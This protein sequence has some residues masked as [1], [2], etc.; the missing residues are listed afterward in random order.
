M[1]ATPQKIYTVS[2]LNRAAGQ[3]LEHHFST[4]TVEGEIGRFTAASSGHWY[5]S[6][7]DQA[8]QLDCAMFRSQN[9]RV[10]PLPGV[11]DRVRVQG[12]IGIYETRG[13]FQLVVETLEQSG[14]GALAQ[15][16]ERL[17]KRLE[18]EGLFARE[19]KQALPELPEHL[20]VITSATGAALQDVLKVLRRRY[21]ILP[22]T[23][24]PVVVQGDEAVPQ[25]VAALQTVQ[26]I[27]AE[28]PIDLLLLTRGGGSPEDLW[29][30]N[31]EELVRAV[32]DCS[33]PLIC[34]VG[35]EIDFT[36]AEFAADRR[37]PTPSAA[38]EL[39]SPDTQLW[40]Q[41]LRQQSAE[42][43]RRLL[44]RCSE[45]ARNL[46][47]LRRRLRHPRGYLESHAQRTDELHNRILKAQARRLQEVE[48]QLQ[49][50]RRELQRGL[51]RNSERLGTAA[52]GVARQD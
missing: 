20:A 6:L 29:A 11:G 44:D 3:T 9:R 16:F 36:L 40:G 5:F 32:A 13:S 27:K 28:P 30:F 19:R 18:A 47:H 50:L 15:A 38:A 7:K 52:A 41:Q 25:I 39:L 46:G 35:H 2:E 8:A 12:R 48:P 31:E 24:V 21:P 26:R 45:L 43:E 49:T 37:A 4:V 1:D 17:K 14:S 10:K 23:V 42:L 34:A 33:L 22:V 51:Q